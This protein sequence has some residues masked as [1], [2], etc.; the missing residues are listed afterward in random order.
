MTEK[1]LRV[2]LKK[3]HPGFR[4]KNEG[5]GIYAVYNNDLKLPNKG[6][7]LAQHLAERALVDIKKLVCLGISGK[8]LNDAWAFVAA[9]LLKKYPDPKKSLYK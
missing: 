7:W 2:A 9:E 6:L 4:L 3:I 1:Q 5:H 8:E